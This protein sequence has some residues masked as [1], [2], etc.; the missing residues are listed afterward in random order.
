MLNIRHNTLN[1][2]N[3]QT[4]SFGPEVTDDVPQH[5]WPTWRYGLLKPKL[6]SLSKVAYQR[7]SLSH[8]FEDVSYYCP[9]IICEQGDFK[10]RSMNVKFITLVTCPLIF[11]LNK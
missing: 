11:I 1:R 8:D 10:D 5:G 9:E 4:V 2:K 6:A 3:T 7:T